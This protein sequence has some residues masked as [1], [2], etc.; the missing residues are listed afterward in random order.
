MGGIL[1][2]L[3]VGISVYFQVWENEVHSSAKKSYLHTKFCH[4]TNSSFH[5]F[6]SSFFQVRLL[7]LFNLIPKSLAA[8]CFI[9]WEFVFL[10][11]LGWTLCCI[12]M[13]TTDRFWEIFNFRFVNYGAVNCLFVMIFLGTFFVG[14]SSWNRVIGTML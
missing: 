3:T 14:W 1:V 8:K 7:P 12:I 11:V 4:P 6:F 10:I 5:S 9:V 2:S 13:S